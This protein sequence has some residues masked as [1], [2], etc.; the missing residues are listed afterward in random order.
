MNLVFKGLPLCLILIIAT[1][2]CNNAPNSTKY[3]YETFENVPYDL[4]VHTLKNGLKIYLVPNQDEPTIEAFVSVGTGS[5]RDPNHLTGLAHYLEHLLFNGTDSIGAFDFEREK[6]LLDEISKKFEEHRLAQDP[7]QKKAIFKIID[8]LSFA[9]SK[10]ANFEQRDMMFKMGAYNNNASTTTYRTKFVNKIPANQLEKWILIYA[11]VFRNPVFRGFQNELDA[12]FEELS[13]DYSNGYGLAGIRLHE[14]TF[15]NQ[16][17]HKNTIGKP[18]HIRNPSIKETRQFFDTYYVPNNMAIGLVGDFDPDEAVEWIENSYFGRMQSSPIPELNTNDTPFLKS[19]REKTI[20]TSKKDF[21]E[22]YFVGPPI[23]SEEGH[24]L[25]FAE[26]LF[27]NGHMDL[28]TISELD[29]KSNWLNSGPIFHEDFTLHWIQSEPK[30]GISLK[31]LNNAIVESINR[32]KTGDYPDWLL[33]AV[34]N[35]LNKRFISNFSNT[36][37]SYHLDRIFGYKISVADFFGRYD[38]FKQVTKEDLKHFA[39]KYYNHFSIIYSKNG[40]SDFEAFEKVPNTALSDDNKNKD[41]DFSKRIAGI[42]T[43]N[44]EPLFVDFDK[45]VK[46]IAL[47]NGNLISYVK[48]EANH[49]FKMTMVLKK[50]AG[51]NQLPLAKKYLSSASSKDYS[52]V[53]FKS[54]LFKLGC[55]YNLKDDRNNKD[56]LL[57]IISGLTDNF[58]Q[59]I[60]LIHNHFSNLKPDVALFNEVVEQQHKQL[61]NRQNSSYFIMPRAMDYVI[62]GPKKVA[63]SYI[64]KKELSELSADGFVKKIAN[65][66]NRKLKFEIFIPSDV[67]YIKTTLDDIFKK[68]I[69]EKTPPKKKVKPIYQENNVYL[70]D[71]KTTQT[72]IIYLTNLKSY[73]KEKIALYNLLTSYSKFILSDEIRGRRGLAYHAHT[74]WR[75]NDN[76][77]PNSF[78][79]TMKVAA[80]NANLA[81]TEAVKVVKDLPF[82]ASDFEKRKEGTIGILNSER[83][84]GEQVLSHYENSKRKGF[85]IDYRKYLLEAYPQ[86]TLE[87]FRT[88]YETEIQNNYYN[89][90]VVGDIS[91]LD[92]EAL[93]QYGKIN[94]L[95]AEDLFSGN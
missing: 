37:I 43:S 76:T 51:D 16:V 86:T 28:F 8:S 5:K 20:Y 73:D 66:F 32:L 82:K 31:E 54:E 49:L 6:P 17:F 88:F 41:S 14:N 7:E 92:Q 55:S 95:K 57:I 34:A 29:K 25:D 80:N 64:N 79:A 4:K 21:L 47:E 67:E 36:F 91:K 65:L 74:E 72:S 26:M 3:D 39:N 83:F 81:I 12:V 53:E 52:P 62:Y 69:I 30:D 58:A 11:E 18:E 27:I 56:N 71:L 23:N 46:T 1:F 63:S 19:N 33:E 2:S 84:V 90:I 68:K 9:A 22:M 42:A 15:P 89:L 61:E 87:D 38:K 48:N 40:K 75:D 78:Y 59:S 10:Y 93:K 24:L 60:R 45:Q 70:I 13:E 50:R 35:E 44:I 77:Q 94:L 85:D